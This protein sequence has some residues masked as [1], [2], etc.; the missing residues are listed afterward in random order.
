MTYPQD[1][2]EFLWVP[3]NVENP[4]RYA[5]GILEEWDSATFANA[6]RYRGAVLRNLAVINRVEALS[7]T[8][9]QQV[10]LIGHSGTG[11][12]TSFAILGS[13]LQPGGTAA[14]EAIQFLQSTVAKEISVEIFAER[15]FSDV[16]PD[17]EITS[18]TSYTDLATPGPS[19]TAD[20]TSTGLAVV[21]IGSFAA[22]TKSSAI[23]API[24]QYAL[25]AYEISGA[26]TR[27]PVDLES[28][29][30]GA[31]FSAAESVNVRNGSSKVSVVNGLNAGANT[32][33]AKYRA[34]NNFNDV[35]FADRTLV[36]IAF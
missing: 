2:N 33:T 5:I 21:M 20:I 6:V 15:I 34:A 18:S 28:H 19:V 27:S 17:L 8:V 23:G 25:M 1:E 35:G 24:L 13:Y 12:I 31:G 26:T 11:P 14:G 16:V 36:V 22:A 4:P 7:F 30:T 32:F 10:A 3:P 9:G 29:A